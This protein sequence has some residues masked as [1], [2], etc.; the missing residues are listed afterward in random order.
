[1][2]GA[3]G[4]P[5]V[6]PQAW[7]VQLLD[8]GFAKFDVLFGDRVVFLLDQ[9]IG[10][11]ARVLFGH[12]VVTSVG[13]GDQ[14]DLRNDGLGHGKPRGS[15]AGNL[16]GGGGKSRNVETLENALTFLGIKS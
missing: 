3:L 2:K 7:V 8:L 12:V 11:G 10:H 13:A 6:F 15:L 16:M 14:F 9:L 5:F 4:R 1:M